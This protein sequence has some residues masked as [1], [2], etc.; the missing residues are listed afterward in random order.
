ML[1]IE[2]PRFERLPIDSAMVVGN[3]AVVNV[4]AGL[5]AFLETPGN[6]QRR[7][8]GAGYQAAL[9]V[10]FGVAVT[11]T[12]GALGETDPQQ[13]RWMVRSAS[14][15]Y[16]SR[17]RGDDR[18]IA[19]AS[20]E[21]LTEHDAFVKASARGSE[22]GELLSANLR[23]IAMRGGRY[24][25]DA[26]GNLTPSSAKPSIA[27]VAPTQPR[28][29]VGVDPFDEDRPLLR[30]RPPR[31]VATGARTELVFEPDILKLLMNPIA[32]HRS[33]L[34]RRVHP[35]GNAPF[36]AAL[37]TALAAAGEADPDRPVRTHIVRADVTWLLPLSLNGPWIA[38][39]REGAPQQDSATRLVE[40][41]DTDARKVLQAAIEWS[42]T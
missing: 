4:A 36:G 13:D 28:E 5:I 16:R 18:I 19:Q 35:L 10:P 3:E 34:G 24:A 1:H 30:L 33:P 39:T 2:A 17:A 20:I 41:I 7:P 27:N 26:A 40:V 32:G 11:A 31:S 25:A 22:S 15:R 37:T 6:D 42:A 21:R 9:T 29:N 38:R 23:V 12:L 14:V 8:I